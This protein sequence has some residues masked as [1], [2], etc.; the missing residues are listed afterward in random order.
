MRKI[1]G[2]LEEITKNVFGLVWAEDDSVYGGFG[3]NQGFVILEDSVLVFDT[4]I[5]AWHAQMLNS[6]VKSVTDKKIKFVVNSHDHS[7]HIF[8]NSY[9]LDRYSKTGLVT[10]S[11]DLCAS[12][13][14]R[15]GEKRMRGYKRIS[16]LK[17]LLDPLRI[18]LP[19][20]TYSN[21]GF[22]IQIQGVEF[23]FAH[24]ATGAHTLGDTLL[25]LP[26]AE[27]FFSGDI[28]WNH[29]LPNLEDANLEGWVSTMKDLDLATYSKCLPGHGEVCGP[30]EIKEFLEYLKSVKENLA[31]L[32]REGNTR[33]VEEQ[34][35]CF[36][37]PGSENWRLRSIIEY[38]VNALFHSKR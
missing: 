5:S 7:D 15:F 1:D 4:G 27:F 26:K 3:A 36:E 29:F 34:K 31:R 24:P 22:K 23:V 6:A 37:V 38:N 11:H 30:K 9:F 17:P 18:V 8:G 10:I 33:D 13:L 20:I 21:L 35:R 2:R 14:D 19:E 25:F 32:E 16:R 28:I 12:Q